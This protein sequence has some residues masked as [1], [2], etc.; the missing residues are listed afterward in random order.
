MENKVTLPWGVKG[1][2]RAATISPKK[3]TCCVQGDSFLWEYREKR[4]FF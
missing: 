3:E 2:S 1:A 4:N